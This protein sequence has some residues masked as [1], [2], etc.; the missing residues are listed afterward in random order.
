MLNRPLL[1]ADVSLYDLCVYSVTS[2]TFWRVDDTFSEL[3][4][5]S[6]IKKYR[7]SNCPYSEQCRKGRGNRAVQ[8]NVRNDK[9]R[10]KT[11]A[12]FISDT[13]VKRCIKPE[14]VF[15]D[16]KFNHGFKR[17]M[18]NGLEKGVIKFGLTALAHNL[19]KYSRDVAGELCSGNVKIA[20]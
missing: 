3:G 6:P 10:A 1:M 18:L 19:R 16:S 11:K 4:Y 2:L 13:G 5:K 15:C 12:L 8:V 14:A 17:F 9:Y 20:A 7:C